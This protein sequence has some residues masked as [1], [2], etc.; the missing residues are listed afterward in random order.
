[1]PSTRRN[2]SRERNQTRRVRTPNPYRVAAK[3]Y[4]NDIKNLRKELK[5]IQKI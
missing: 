1:M 5:V 2:R 4:V 3:V